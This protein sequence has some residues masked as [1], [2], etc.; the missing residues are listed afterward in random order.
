MRYAE[1]VGKDNVMGGTDCGLGTRVGHPTIAWAK[2][3]SL[4][5]GA[6]RA[7]EQLFG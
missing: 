2:F 6:R 4:V 7:S 1:L 3:E 5:E